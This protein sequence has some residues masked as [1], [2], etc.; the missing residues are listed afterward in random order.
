MGK[1]FNLFYKKKKH[2][3]KLSEKKL[4]KTIKKPDLA[5]IPENDSNDSNDISASDILQDYREEK[6]NFELEKGIIIDKI[7]DYEK[8][9][10]SLEQTIIKL[11]GI[12]ED[13]ET[14]IRKAKKNSART[15]NCIDL[16]IIS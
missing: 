10:K 9:I 2:N 3:D 7:A 4:K 13:K 8:K 14:I 16:C 11:Y 15:C 6:I 12:I 5:P 1:F